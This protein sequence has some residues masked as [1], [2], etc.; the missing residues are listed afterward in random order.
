MVK[1]PIVRCVTK[2][3]VAEHNRDEANVI[4]TDYVELR[5]F[6]KLVVK[7]ALTVLILMER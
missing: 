2:Q 6:Q 4:M 1:L 5:S 7:Q 3:Q